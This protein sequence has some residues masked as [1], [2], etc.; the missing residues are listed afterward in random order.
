MK[1]GDFLNSINYTKEDLFQSSDDPF[2]EKDYVPFIISRSLSY[3][4]DTIFHV[5]EVN[6]HGHLSKNMHYDYLRMSVRKRKR[7]SKWGKKNKLEHLDAVKKYYNYS[8]Q[9]AEEALSI[10]TDDQLSEI[11]K[12]LDVGGV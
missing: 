1:L 11:E 10:L 6:K 7:F 9:R 2:V 12:F 8:N 5:N 3:F 4:P